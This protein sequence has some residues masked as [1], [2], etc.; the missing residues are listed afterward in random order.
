MI[1]SF[2][3]LLA[4]LF[5]TQCSK[6][7]KDV[8]F[9]LLNNELYF[10]P[11]FSHAKGTGWL[12]E[13][14]LTPDDKKQSNNPI[15]YSITNNLPFEILFIPNN[16]EILLLTQEEAIGYNNFGLSYTIIHENGNDLENF[17]A[18][19]QKGEIEGKAENFKK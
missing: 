11:I 1:A 8:E 13:D 15:R 2:R 12:Y 18:L 5:L 4:I 19:I 14:Y 16:Q 7:L 10:A 17:S 9:E 3:I 6:P